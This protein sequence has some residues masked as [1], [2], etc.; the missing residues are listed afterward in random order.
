MR[1]VSLLDK[2]TGRV[3]SFDAAGAEVNLVANIVR[4]R[5]ELVT[6]GARHYWA[7]GREFA[8]HKRVFHGGGHY[9]KD[10]AT[11]NDIEGYFSIFKRGMRGIYQWCSER[12]LHRY[13][14]EFDF[15]YSNREA[16]GYNDSDRA[17]QVLRGVIGKRLT[18][19]RI[20]ERQ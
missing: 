14:S 1:I 17:D 20:G 11:T 19:G 4:P 7:V 6:D 16:A 9:V 12:H 13:L 2:G 10:G 18:Y 8:G 15:R 3:R 5:S